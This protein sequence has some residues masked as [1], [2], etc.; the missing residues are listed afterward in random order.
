MLKLLMS[1]CIGTF[2]AFFLTFNGIIIKLKHRLTIHYAIP[3]SKREFSTSDL[4]K[5]NHC[6]TLDSHIPHVKPR[7]KI[8]QC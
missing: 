8:Q 7:V 5:L 3:N 4:K 6:T 2:I 1:Y